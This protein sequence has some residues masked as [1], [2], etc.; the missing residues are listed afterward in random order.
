MQKAYYLNGEAIMLKSS[1]KGVKVCEVLKYAN[2]WQLLPNGT[3]V[4]V[5]NADIAHLAINNLICPA[6]KRE[7]VLKKAK[8]LGLY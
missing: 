4:L 1:K 7:F 3:I 2:D 8:E 5:K 6:K